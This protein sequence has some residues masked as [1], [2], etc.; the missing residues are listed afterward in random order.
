MIAS[1][2]PEVTLLAD[3]SSESNE[4]RSLLEA[5][6][7]P[8]RV[9]PA[10]DLAPVLLIGGQAYSGFRR[11]Q[12]V[13]E[14]LSSVGNAWRERLGLL[15][16]EEQVENMLRKKNLF[17][18]GRLADAGILLSLPGSG[19]RVYPAFQFS[20]DGLPNPVV[21]DAL[22][23]LMQADISEFTAAGWFV[24]PQKELDDRTP[25][26]WIVSD[27]DPEALLRVARQTAAHLS[28]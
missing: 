19:G 15:W 4:V 27:G 9:T 20:R 21:A 24:T 22:D 1:A 14:M 12:L 6:W 16:D 18:A 17:D 5:G 10:S 2:L 23:L 8:H 3:H 11:V 25:A 28:Q 26:E 13:V 7:I